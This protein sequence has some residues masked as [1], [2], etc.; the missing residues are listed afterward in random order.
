MTQDF[1]MIASRRILISAANAHTLFNLACGKSCSDSMKFHG[2]HDKCLKYDEKRVV[3]R[4]MLDDE[5][6]MQ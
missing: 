3:P 4:K 2:S 6:F 5:I 1:K